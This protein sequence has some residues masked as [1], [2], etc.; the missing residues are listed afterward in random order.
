MSQAQKCADLREQGYKSLGWENDQS[1]E[2]LAAKKET[3]FET[4]DNSNAGW[5][6]FV[7]HEKKLYYCLDSGD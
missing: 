1:P 5:Q 4:L 7:N 6:I 3:R 2:L